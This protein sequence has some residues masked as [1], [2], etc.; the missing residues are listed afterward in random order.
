MLETSFGDDGIQNIFVYQPTYSTFDLKKDK[1]NLYVIGC[2]SK[3]LFESKL[4]PVP[5]AFSPNIKYFE[6]KIEIQFD[7]ITLIVEQNNYAIKIVNT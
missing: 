2:K 4:L 7:N 3:A 6:Y 5:G 1:G